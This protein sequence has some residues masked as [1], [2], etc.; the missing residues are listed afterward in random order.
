MNLFREVV[1][2]ECMDC[3]GK[4]EHGAE[5]L[6]Q[7]E[8][9]S[10]IDQLNKIPVDEAALEDLMEALGE[11]ETLSD[12]NPAVVDETPAIVMEG[13]TDHL[14]DLL[15]RAYEAIK[16]FFAKMVEWF[17]SVVMRRGLTEERAKEAEASIEDYD[18]LIQ[19]LQTSIS[20]D[21][22]LERAMDKHFPALVDKFNGTQKQMLSG[23]EYAKGMQDLTNSI[24]YTQ[25]GEA[26]QKELDQSHTWYNEKI[27]QAIDF[28]AKA[29][30]EGHDEEAMTKFVESLP[31][32]HQKKV[33]ASG[34]SLKM[35]GRMLARVEK[36]KTLN[37]QVHLHD[38]PEKLVSSA[39]TLVTHARY[40]DVA[41]RMAENFHSIES[42]QKHLEST[43][44]HQGTLLD[45]HAQEK[46]TRAQTAVIRVHCG[47]LKDLLMDARTSLDVMR[48]VQA[49][50]FDTVSM[51][52]AI[53]HYAI[54]VYEAVGQ[55]IELTEDQKNH[56]AKVKE[57]FH[58]TQAVAK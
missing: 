18:A 46:V 47:Y 12:G 13:M 35:L 3:T 48:E 20:R 7:S 27:Q 56:L 49:N 14:K 9:E 45:H 40:V 29:A 2:Q 51:I 23:G 21:Q 57:A 1:A 58:R 36:S 15:K 26:I 41:K 10:I 33:N 31:F 43:L 50:F 22:V 52:L 17:K 16:N 39:S 42:I 54:S 32:D 53:Q 55:E 11:M 8:G 25:Y 34:K 44:T 5:V 24:M 19:R 28:D 4:A 38:D 6:E 37:P 30:E